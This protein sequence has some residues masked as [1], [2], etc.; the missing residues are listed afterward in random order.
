MLEDALCL[1][2]ADELQGPA[3]A[4]ARGGRPRLQAAL[5]AR[6]LPRRS[7]ATRC[8]PRAA[9]RR[10]S[11]STGTT[12]PS[13]APRPARAPTPSCA[14]RSTRAPSSPASRASSRRRSSLWGREDRIYPV[15]RAH[16]LVREIPGAKLEIMDAGHVAARRAPARVPRA[17]HRVPGGQAVSWAPAW[18][19]FRANRPAMLG[20]AL[21]VALALFA[22]VGP[23]VAR[24][25]PGRE[26]LRAPPRP[27]RRPARPLR[28][29]LARHRPPLP[30][31]PRPPRP[32]RPRLARRRRS[33]PPRSPPASAPPRASLAG[34]TRGHPLRRSSTRS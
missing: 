23:L 33:P 18:A 28:R 8:T 34:M 12:T 10:S 27:A 3:A 26:R 29:A 11:A 9:R 20:L 2:R 15:R 32:R 4:R 1:P 13:T 19:R 21:V 14:P 22:L 16:R 30:R 6:H 31:R 25:G 7:S 24:L 5:R 17:A